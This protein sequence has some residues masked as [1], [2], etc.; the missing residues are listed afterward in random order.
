MPK[1]F[2]RLKTNWQFQILVCE[3]RLIFE[4][5]VLGKCTTHYQKDEDTQCFR[6]SVSFNLLILSQRFWIKSLIFL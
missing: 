3:K 2:F 4:N 1:H 5:G 6:R